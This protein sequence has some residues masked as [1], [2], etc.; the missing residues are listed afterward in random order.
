MDLQIETIK[1]LPLWIQLPALDIKYW[2]VG[3]LSKLGSLLGIPIKTDK[4]TKDKQVLRYA[5]LLVEMII[6]GS[7]PEFIEF[8]NEENLLI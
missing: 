7:F 5:P 4:F 3:S 6:D 8:F 2:G 1:S